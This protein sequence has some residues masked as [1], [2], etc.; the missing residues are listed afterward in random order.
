MANH[1]VQWRLRTQ[2]GEYAVSVLPDGSGLVLDHWGELIAGDLPAW[3][4]P[5]QRIVFATPSDFA[6]LEYASAGQRHVTFSELLIDR[7]NSLDGA[8]WSVDYGAAR[9][10]RNGSGDSL[11]VPFLDEAQAI[12]LTLIVST[13][14]SHDVVRRH[15]RVLNLSNDTISLPRA[16][17]AGWNIP[18]GQAVRVEY[19]AGSWSHE[20]QRRHVDLDW[21]SFTIGSRQGVTGHLF[22][23]VVTLTAIPNEDSFAR[24]SDRAFGV[25]LEWSGSWR[26]QVDSVPHGQT[27]RVSTGVHEDTSTITLS[28][29]EEFVA[30]DSLGV[31]SPHGPGGV[32]RAWHHFQRTSLARELGPYHRPIVYNSWYATTFDVRAEHQMELARQAR[33]LGVEVFVVD[34]GW[35]VGRTSDSAGLGD[36]VADPAKFPQGLGAFASQ[37]VNL[38]MRF[39]VW[40]EPECV[41]PD[42]NV[43]RNHPEWVY[44]AGSRPLVTIRDQYV[45]DLGRDDVVAWLEQ[46]LRDLLASSEISYLK[47]DM[48]RPISDG[49]RPGDPHGRE[50]SIQHTRNYYRLLRMLRDEFPHVT[51]EACAAGGGRVD[52][53]VLA[54]SDVVWTSDEVGARDRLV[55]QDGFLTAFPQ[56]AM[57]SWVSDELGHRDRYPTSL[58][59]RF[60]VSMSGVLG[61]GSDLLAWDE[62]DRATARR[63]I[64]LYRAIRG[65][66]HRATVVTHGTPK[67]DLYA[68]EFCGP[69]EDPRIVI[70]VYR[71]DRWHRPDR[72]RPRVFPSQLDPNRRYR[73]NDDRRE[74]VR[75][76]ASSL[77]IVVPFDFADDADVLVLTPIE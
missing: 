54:L 56:H 55:I 2:T 20:F 13:S 76:E 27:V 67:D 70:F 18:L 6:P 38:G 23:P 63:A 48:N 77:G 49:G 59:F 39:G 50:W 53:A 58:G 47:W 8:S 24:H 28:P 51:V 11:E 5:D 21:G 52:S 36:W 19:L 29:G 62:A 14:S 9:L 40:I 60:A 45:L 15:V 75:E 31:F 1:E 42:S 4:E 17:S 25:C 32:S 74:V 44:R 43:F 72:C 73:V 3:S 34:D 35:F 16:F 64:E 65:V 41:N 57:S 12:R 26:L 30:P 66:T 7:G 22:S 69:A 71:R 46:T 61:I 33:D 68:I 10:T 37:V